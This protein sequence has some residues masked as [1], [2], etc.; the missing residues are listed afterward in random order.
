MMSKNL[1]IRRTENRSFSSVS[2]SFRNQNKHMFLARTLHSPPQALHGAET[3]SS[4]FGE[5]ASFASL[6][7]L[8]QDIV[9]ECL[10][11]GKR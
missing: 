7:P 6:V 10:V 1:P 5:S 3:R 2:M 11:G 9:D 4:T 8:R